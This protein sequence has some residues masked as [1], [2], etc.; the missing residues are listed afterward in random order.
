MW[1]PFGLVSMSMSEKYIHFC[2]QLKTFLKSHVDKN[3]K[4][5]RKNTLKIT[6]SKVVYLFDK[7]HIFLESIF[8]NKQTNN[9]CKSHEL[10]EF[11]GS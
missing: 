9:F 3:F 5:L 10:M 7:R 4:E 1:C 2:T 6:I 11:F 8:H